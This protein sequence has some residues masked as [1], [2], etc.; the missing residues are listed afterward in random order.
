[1]WSKIN[2]FIVSIEAVMGMSDSFWDI[3]LPQIEPTFIPGV[4]RGGR[5]R[6][7][8]GW[9][10]SLEIL[11]EI[12]KGNRSGRG[13]SFFWPLK[14]TMFVAGWLGDIS[15]IQKEDGVL[16]VGRLMFQ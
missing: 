2:G 6:I 15:T 16:A 5:L 3:D 13:L 11:N 8:K 12:P 10:W 14:E 9:E 1:M 7:W 4:G